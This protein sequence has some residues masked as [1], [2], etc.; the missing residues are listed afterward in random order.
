MHIFHSI[1]QYLKPLFSLVKCSKILDHCHIRILTSII[2]YQ[3]VN[4]TC[5]KHTSADT[6]AEL[7]RKNPCAL[8]YRTV[9]CDVPYIN[10]V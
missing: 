10:A 6:S 5:K 3:E 1:A 2:S 4:V 9:N 7:V 8:A